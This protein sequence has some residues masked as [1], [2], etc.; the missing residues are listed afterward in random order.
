MNSMSLISIQQISISTQEDKSLGVQRDRIWSCSWQFLNLQLPDY[1]FPLSLLSW[2]PLVCYIRVFFSKLSIKF[3]RLVSV[4]WEFETSFMF[5]FCSLRWRNPIKKSLVNF[6]QNS[7]MS[8]TQNEIL[9][10]DTTEKLNPFYPLLRGVRTR[11]RVI[12]ALSGGVDSAVSAFLLKQQV[13]ICLFFSS[14]NIRTFH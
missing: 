3:L 7:R 12:V 1:S 9:L 14:P 4:V 5:K 8:Y 2:L 13:S 6:K 11:P 10:T